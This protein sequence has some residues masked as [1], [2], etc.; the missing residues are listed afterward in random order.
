MIMYE[1]VTPIDANK[2]LVIG[3]YPSPDQATSA[4][5]N[6]YVSENK[7]E[8]TFTIRKTTDEDYV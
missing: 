4:A 2:E 1:V 3:V 6:Y 5:Y 7:G 8:L